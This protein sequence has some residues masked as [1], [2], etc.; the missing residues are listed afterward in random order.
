MSGHYAVY[1]VTVYRYPLI[2][3]L[4]ILVQKQGRNCHARQLSWSFRLK[5][6]I[7]G[8]ELVHFIDAIL[9]VTYPDKVEHYSWRSCVMTYPHLSVLAIIFTTTLE[10]T[11]Q[12]PF[13]WHYKCPNVIQ[14]FLSNTAIVTDVGW[15]IV[16]SATY[17]MHLQFRNIAEPYNTAQKCT[18]YFNKVDNNF[19]WL[20]KILLSGFMRQNVTVTV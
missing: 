1:C 5:F 8:V 3:K 6:D 19:L 9:P 4:Y 11:F 20:H 7:L 2:Y 17:T 16:K 13:R 12:N 10:F 15:K 14:D 18:V